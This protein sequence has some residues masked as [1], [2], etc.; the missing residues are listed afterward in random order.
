[1]TEE[2]RYGVEVRGGG[3]SPVDSISASH[4][5]R[6]VP[7]KIAVGREFE[8]AGLLGPVVDNVDVP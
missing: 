4:L 3:R 5:P 7:R 8:L 6:D 2:G 1:M